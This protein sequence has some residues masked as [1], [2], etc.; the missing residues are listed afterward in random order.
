M[1]FCLIWQL[2]LKLINNILSPIFVL[3]FST[4][5]SSKF[6]S[7]P[8]IFQLKSVQ[9]GKIR[10]R[11]QACHVTYQPKSCFMKFWLADQ[12]KLAF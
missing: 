2:K 9:I 6:E 3:D 11:Y 12:A 8:K 1:D 10:A 5:P 4:N 7:R